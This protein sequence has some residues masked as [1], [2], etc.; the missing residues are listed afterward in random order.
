MFGVY[1]GAEQQH[2][3][4]LHAFGS[5]QRVLGVYVVSHAMRICLSADACSPLVTQR[6]TAN[7]HLW[8]PNSL[9]VPL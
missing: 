9:S 6:K 1:L 5:T 4:G 8:P 7:V 3:Y 2:P